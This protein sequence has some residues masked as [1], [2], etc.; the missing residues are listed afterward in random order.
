[1]KEKA[2]TGKEKIQTPHDPEARYSTKR[3]KSWTGYKVHVTETANEKGEVNFVTDI[4][5]TN[6][7]ER[8]NETL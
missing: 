4:T 3:G 8:D 5:T 6:A 1:M 7:C 2:T